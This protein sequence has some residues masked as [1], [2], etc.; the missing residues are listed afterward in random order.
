MKKLIIV[1]VFVTAIFGSLLIVVINYTQ[2]QSIY[3]YNIDPDGYK[4]IR[5]IMEEVVSVED[6]SYIKKVKLIDVSDGKNQYPLFSFIINEKGNKKILLVGGIHGDEPA[7]AHALI[8]VIKNAKDLSVKYPNT[9]ITIIPVLNPW[10]FVYDN[11]FNNEGINI[12]VDFT[13][14]LSKESSH[15][16][17]FIENRKFDLILDLHETDGKSSYLLVHDTSDI[18][19]ALNII[20]I[21]KNQGVK[22]AS[23]PTMKPFRVFANHPGIAYYPYVVSLLEMFAQRETLFVY[24]LNRNITRKAIA[25]ETGKSNDI[26]IRKKIN[27]IIIE[28]YLNDYK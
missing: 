23:Q 12:G 25:V 10:G 17:K 11:L 14:K 24:M 21:L 27:K 18:P 26:E 1:I 15:I 20:T 19:K 7:G 9:S 3:K 16:V 6:S 13:N 5:D 8:D 22:I 4:I 28:E 2:S